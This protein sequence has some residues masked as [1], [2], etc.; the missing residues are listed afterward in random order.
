MRRVTHRVR[1][2]GRRQEGLKVSH[3]QSLH[4]TVVVIIIVMRRE[5]ERGCWWIAC[6]RRQSEG[7]SL[8]CNY[9]WLT[10]AACILCVAG[11]E[12]LRVSAARERVSE[13]SDVSQDCAEQRD[14][15][16]EGERRNGADEDED[17][18]TGRV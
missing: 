16:R 7:F 2:R 9:H 4:I 12:C 17:E 6:E 5:R 14:R 11:F 3:W 1:V 13:G 15:M 8:S 18:G 10:L